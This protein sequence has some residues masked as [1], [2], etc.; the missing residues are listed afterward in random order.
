MKRQL[1]KQF[2]C[3]ELGWSPLINEEHIF[4]GRIW[5]K[6]GLPINFIDGSFSN[7]EALLFHVADFADSGRLINFIL[8]P[9]SSWANH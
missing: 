5:R 9:S 3:Q 7:F 2:K 8:S 4:P 1:W 6:G